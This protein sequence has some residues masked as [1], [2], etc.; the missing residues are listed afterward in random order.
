MKNKFIHSELFSK[1]LFT[2]MMVVLMELGRQIVIPS[3]DSSMS[4]QVL[5]ASPLLR[6]LSAL[7]GGQ[8]NYPSLFSVGLGPYMT[9]MILFQAIQL[10]DIDELNK[11]NDYKRG[12]I[13]RWI[14]FVI[15]LLQT[16]QFIIVNLI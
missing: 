4:R 7:T 13:Q 15:A 14:S 5:E 6:N 2:L 1:V 11:I 12:M 8:A 10:L 3:L 16:L 9:G